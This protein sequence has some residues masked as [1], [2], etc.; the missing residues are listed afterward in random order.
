MKSHLYHIQVN[1]NFANITFYQELMT[2]LGWQVI[3]ATEGVVGYKSGQSGD[4]W[5]C[6]AIKNEQGDYDKTGVNHISIRVENMGDI[7]KFTEF[8]RKKNIKLLFDTP[9]HRS[10]FV[11]NESET[12]YQAMFASPDNMLFEIVYIGPKNDTSK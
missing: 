8:L 5:F 7:D 9:R 10:D 6:K 1:I 4:I 3:F 2:Y 12:Y 11:S